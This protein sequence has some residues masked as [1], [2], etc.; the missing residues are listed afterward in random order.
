MG[1]FRQ[2]SFR[3]S[4]DFRHIRFHIHHTCIALECHAAMSI[5]RRRHRLHPN[6]VYLSPITCFPLQPCPFE[7]DRSALTPT[8]LFSIKRNRPHPPSDLECNHSC[9]VDRDRSSTGHTIH[10]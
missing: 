8:V 7:R 10:P 6:C 3:Q 5:P 1:G 9:R 4:K 2:C